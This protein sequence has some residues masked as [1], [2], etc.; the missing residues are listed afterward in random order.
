MVATHTNSEPTR[1]ERALRIRRSERPL[2]GWLTALFTVIQASHGFGINAADALF[3]ERYG[4]DQ[5]PLMILLSGPAV[6]VSVLGHSS[7]LASRG[8]ARWLPSVTLV[9]ALWAAGEWAGILTGSQVV[10]PIIWISTQVLMMVSLTVMWNAAGAACTSRQAKRLFPIFATAG[11]AGGVLGNFLTGI[12]AGV[13][14]T[15]N[16]L[17]VQ[18]GLLLTGALL[19]IRI[20]DLFE[21]DSSEHS[22]STLKGLSETATIIRSSRFLRITAGIAVAIFCL[23]QLVYF[24]FSQ[25]VARSFETEAETAA[26]LGIFS[27]IA[28][29][30]TFLFSLFVTNR[31]FARVGLVLTLMIVPVVYATGF[32]TWL[33]VFTLESA[34]IFRLVQWVTVNAIALTAYNALFNVVSRHQRG[35]VNA[36]MT[37]VPAQIGVSLAGLFLMTTFAMPVQTVFVIGLVVSLLTLG[38]VVLLRKEYLNA[39]VSAVR[40]GVVGLLDV[41]SQAVFTPTDADA[42]RVL[43]DRLRDPRPAARALAV[44]GLGRLEGSADATDLEPFLD[45]SDP[46]VRSAAFDSVCAIEPERVSSHAERAIGDEVPE[47]RLQVLHFLAAHPD[48]EAVSI[49]RAALTDPDARVRA[50]AATLVGGEEGEEV[51]STL[52]SEDTPR[53]VTAVLTETAKETSAISV[54]PSPYLRHDSPVVREAATRTSLDAGVE[55]SALRPGLDD[56][57]P[58]VRTATA[59]VLAETQEGREIL[60]DVLATGSVSASESALKALTPLEEFPEEF[61]DW[62]RQEAER[63]AFLISQAGALKLAERPTEAHEYLVEVLENRGRRLVRWVLMAM[64]TSDTR[65]VMPLVARGVESSDPDT[66]AQAIEA[67]ESIG[68][69]DVMEVLLPL[70]ESEDTSQDAHAGESLRR[71]S[72]DF[73]PW[74]RDLAVRA[75][76]GEEGGERHSLPSLSNMDEDVTRSI[77]DTLDRVLVLQRVHMFSELDP[78][79]LD[80]IA[81][82][83]TEEVYEPGAPIFTEGEAGEEML[84]IVEGSAVVTVPEGS[85]TRLIREYGPGDHVGELSLLAGQPRSANVHAGEEGLRGLTLTATDLSTVLE[86][87]PTVAVGMLGTLAKRLIE[88]T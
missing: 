43:K 53:G 8:T 49:A 19:L 66:Q 24:P 10:Y 5:L 7:G 13:L 22:R 64:T 51:V 57:S 88:Q 74:L 44:A 75:L 35:Q 60:L 72:N 30:A 68:A 37:A 20:R 38:A 4:V 12:L 42:V 2:V 1:V 61:T 41:P 32:G 73:D 55:P 9:C 29:A 76:D 85:T 65:A 83:T 79:D 52:L 40:R 86:E 6:M 15:E 25:T 36:F 45:D 34:A 47:V 26:F 31:L 82:A 39:V 23:F 58:R 59:A 77:L 56:R 18:A 78:E 80:L 84:V 81:Q 70:L 21:D 69:R 27:A 33:T 3:F 67:L 11:I 54:D 50:A 14:G 62:A 63:A 46:R 16:L 48:D 71:L 28:T 87:R 17:L